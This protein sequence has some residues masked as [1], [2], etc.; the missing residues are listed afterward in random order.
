MLVDHIQK[1]HQLKSSICK[2]VHHKEYQCIF[3]EESVKKKG[4]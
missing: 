1:Y 2:H 4:K 3:N